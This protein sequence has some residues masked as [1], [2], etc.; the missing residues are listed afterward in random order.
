MDKTKPFRIAIAGCF[1][2]L[3]HEALLHNA[4]CNAILFLRYST[5]PNTRVLIAFGL[6]IYSTKGKSRIALQVARKIAPCNST[7]TRCQFLKCKERSMDKAWPEIYMMKRQTFF[8]AKNF[9]FYFVLS[10]AGFA[11][12]MIIDYQRTFLII[13]TR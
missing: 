10:A 3:I 12:L 7:F 6:C 2:A 1:K 11:R 13:I 5:L 4:T 8:L 9:Q